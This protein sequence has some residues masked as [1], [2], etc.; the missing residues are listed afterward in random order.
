MHPKPEIAAQIEAEWRRMYAGSSP[1]GLQKTLDFEMASVEL[2]R[3]NLVP[4]VSGHDVG[5][6]KRLLDFGSGPGASA[7]AIAYDTGA[8]VVGVEPNDGNKVIAPRWAEAY[9]VADKVEF[10]F[11]QDTLNLPFEDESFD[12][13]MASSSLEYIKGDR[14]P[15]IREM[16]RVL[17]TGGRLLVAG[18]SNGA[19]PREVHSGTWTLNWMPNLGPKVREW[20]GRNPDAERGITFGDILAAH[21]SLRF[22]KGRS[23][24]LQAFAS[25]L[26][27]PIESIPV[28][29]GL[30]AVGAS[31]VLDAIDRRTTQTIEWPM[32]AF[33]PWLNVGF[34]KR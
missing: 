20:L 1:A 34:E 21:P 28:L 33:L 7:T 27:E 25:R 6:G 13:V 12:F 26:V 30:S 4:F 8:F 9:D 24:E 10:H 31:R 16:V 2:H 19:W 23:D 17:K 18:T 14:A 29:G 11:I 32:E 22:V 5:A 15:Y 3:K